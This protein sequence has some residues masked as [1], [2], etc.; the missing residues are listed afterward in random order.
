ML[1]VGGPLRGWFNELEPENNLESGGKN[2]EEPH[3]W[4]RVYEL[5]D[6]CGHLSLDGGTHLEHEARV[7]QSV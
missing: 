1:R 6:C 5:A 2:S 3:Y 7:I 4:I